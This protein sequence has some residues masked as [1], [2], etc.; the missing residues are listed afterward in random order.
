MLRKNTGPFND[1][2]W[3]KRQISVIVS[4]IYKIVVSALYCIVPQYRSN[5]SEL[6][7]G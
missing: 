5:P 7:Y 3:V 2:D 6:C 4:I 1:Y